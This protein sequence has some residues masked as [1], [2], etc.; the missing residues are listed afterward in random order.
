MGS[1]FRAFLPLP[2]EEIPRRPERG[3]RVPE[4]P[5]GRDLLVDDTDQVRNEKGYQVEGL[6]FLRSLQFGLLPMKAAMKDNHKTKKELIDELTELRPQNAE[7]KKS[8]A[9]GISAELAA[10]EARRYAESIVDAIRSPLLVLDAD[11][12]ILSANRHF[13]TTFNVIP[14]ETIGCFIYDL[15]NNQWDI[16]LLREL[17]E[18][19]LPEKEAFDDFEVSHDFQD[20]GH[21]VMLLNA[22]QVYRKDI[23]AG[24]ILLAIED[25]TERK[26][27]EALLTESEERFR[28]LFETADDGIVLL[29]S[30]E[31]KIDVDRLI[32]RTDD[33]LY[34]AKREGRNRVC[35]WQDGSAEK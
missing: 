12:K 20:I 17:L 16:P 32:K 13:Y 9:E 29:E 14:S 10:E 22:R 23:D 5:A 31:G 8:T 4:I 30:G 27:L 11:L 2:A 35:A 25:I 18:Q 19:I 7:L 33:A 15:G 28:R 1:V 26:R 3:A 6:R 21:K 24:M 34:K